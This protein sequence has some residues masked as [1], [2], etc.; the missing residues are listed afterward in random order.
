MGSLVIGGQRE[1]DRRCL[2]AVHC[3]CGRTSSCQPSSGQ[4]QPCIASSVQVR[5]RRQ[6]HVHH[7]SAERM[8]GH[9][10]L[11][12]GGAGFRYRHGSDD[13]SRLLHE[14]PGRSCAS[15]SAHDEQSSTARGVGTVPR[16]QLQLQRAPPR[17]VLAS[18][19]GRAMVAL[20]RSFGEPGP[21]VPGSKCG[22]GTDPARAQ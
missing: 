22:G 9:W 21:R 14:P 13:G 20:S 5:S 2:G 18:R 16:W 10:D 8:R 6:S 17:D 1:I 11:L 3:C 7:G 15:S 19:R 4:R 12:Q